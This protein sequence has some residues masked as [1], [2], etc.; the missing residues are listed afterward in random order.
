MKRLRIIIAFIT[1]TILSFVGSL[2]SNV[3]AAFLTPSLAE[4]TWWVYGAWILTFIVSL[5][6][7]LYVFLH[8][9]PDS[10]SST[11]QTTGSHNRGSLSKA[12]VMPTSAANLSTEALIDRSPDKFYIELVGRE[13]TTQ[14]I[15]SVLRDPTNRWMV[16][17]DGMGGIGK[18]AVAQEIALRC[19]S[20]HLFER[21]VWESSAR[22]KIDNQGRKTGTALTFDKALDAIGIQLGDQSIAKIRGENKEKRIRSL[23]HAQRVLVILDNLETASDP[24]DEIARRLLPMLNPGKAL[25][26]SR[27][28]FQG[29][30]YGIH[31]V[32]LAQEDSQRFIRQEANRKGIQQIA[33][34]NSD[35]L[36]IIAE[37]TGGSPLALKL[38]V[39]QVAYL[40]L[41]VVL[42]QLR[43]I[44][45]PAGISEEDDYVH[46]YKGI[47]LPSWR[48]LSPESKG[49]LIGMTHFVPGV[50]GTYEAI[51]NV[52]DLANDTLARCIDQLWKLS[53]LEIGA[54][55]SIDQKRYYLH[56]LTQYFVLSDIVR[57]L[58]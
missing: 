12:D 49:L 35:E 1:S 42:N 54:A 13:T 4:H 21:I 38:I 27:H 43:E 40:P 57:K 32:G 6:I 51:K 33:T 10:T 25:L 23:L 56:P 19:R 28:R 26:T 39:G 34:A 22:N 14:E 8:G 48:L 20:E 3:I 15:M 16:S 29:E 7:T 44:K 46:L 18:T 9:L 2:L 53:F 17:I 11:S 37:T 52:S 36:R 55:Q 41:T 50:G 31:L 45:P 5:P 58:K 24:Q 47:F 30:T